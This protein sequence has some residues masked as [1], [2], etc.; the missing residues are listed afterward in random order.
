MFGRKNTHKKYVDLKYPN[1]EFDSSWEFMVYDFLKMNNISFIYQCNPIQYE[2]NG[3]QHLYFPDFNIAGRLIEIKGDNFFRINEETGKEEMY[4]TWRSPSW[5]D[6]QY[7]YAC[8]LFNAKYQ[9][10]LTNNVIIFRGR[11]VKN[12][13]LNLLHERGIMV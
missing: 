3:K 4:C 2:Y 12:L 1:I 8:G 5:S 13:S 11:D 9:C 7:E 6:E 10:M